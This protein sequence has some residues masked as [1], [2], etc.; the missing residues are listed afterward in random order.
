M[1]HII[2]EQAK[3]FKTREPHVLITI[4][5]KEGSAPR[6][7]GSKMI[8]Y[9]DGSFFGSIGGGATERQA[10]AD[11]IQCMKE[12]TNNAMKT[13]DSPLEQ[14]GIKG[15]GT[16][17]IFMERIDILA[18]LVVCGVGHVGGTVIKYARNLPFFITAMD[19]REVCAEFSDDVNMFYKVEDYAKDI[20]YI[21][22]KKGAFFL[23][24]TFSYEHDIDVIIQIMNKF[25]SYVGV[26]G[27][28]GKRQMLISQLKQRGITCEQLKALYIPVGLDLGGE[29]PEE[30]ALSILSEIQTV[31]YG[32]SGISL[33][34]QHLA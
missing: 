31:R 10:I 30:I 12:W 9:E 14:Y 7:V 34:E 22:I 24:T 3:A 8:V 11:A 5:S 17:T 4:I 13:Y 2:E 32:R 20:G 16:V 1:K 15:H 25:P 21:E 29:M 23:V 6:N 27:S 33:R 28:A 18:D 26:L 19:I